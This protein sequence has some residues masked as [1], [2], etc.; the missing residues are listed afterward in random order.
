VNHRWTQILGKPPKATAQG[1][2]NAEIEQVSVPTSDTNP[3]WIGCQ[4]GCLAALS[5][6]PSVRSGKASANE[7]VIVSP[8]PFLSGKVNAA[9]LIGPGFAAFQ[10]P[11]HLRAGEPAPREPGAGNDMKISSIP[12]SGRKGAV[13]YFNSRYGKVARAHMRPRNPR[14]PAQ[15]D[16]R[17]N[18]RAVS[19]RWC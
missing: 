7:I 4:E 18:V 17:N 1:R 9:G 11:A 3:V 16:H 13:V 5:F 19:G 14:T 12:K 2:Q 6:R 10:T 15:Q 8:C